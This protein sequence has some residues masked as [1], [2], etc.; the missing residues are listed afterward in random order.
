MSL[1]YSVEV[2]SRFK[3]ILNN[4]VNFDSAILKKLLNL[5]NEKLINIPGGHEVGVNIHGCQPTLEMSI[6]V[7][8]TGINPNISTGSVIIG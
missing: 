4:Y 7:Q 1:L 5:P 8:K 3:Q 6:Y 2:F